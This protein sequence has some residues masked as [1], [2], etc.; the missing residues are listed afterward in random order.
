MKSQSKKIEKKNLLE[1][2]KKVTKQR[3]GREKNSLYYFLLNFFSSLYKDKIKKLY[4]KRE[5]PKKKKDDGIKKMLKAKKRIATKQ[6]RFLNR[7]KKMRD[8][9]R[10]EE[11][12]IFDIIFKF[13][14]R[15]EFLP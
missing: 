4:M 10:R 15:L 6:E 3:K 2:E 12:N 5:L 7:I 9:E 11:E 1:R 13:M 8:F 14:L